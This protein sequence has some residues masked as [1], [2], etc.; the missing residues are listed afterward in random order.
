MRLG[1][2][3]ATG[4]EDS[5]VLGHAAATFTTAGNLDAALATYDRAANLA[6][7]SGKRTEAFDLSLAAAAI[8][9]RAQG[10]QAALPRYRQLALRQPLHPR[11]ASA[12]LTAVGLAA[13]LARQ[14]APGSLARRAV[15]RASISSVIGFDIGSPS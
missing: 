4:V 5:T 1:Q 7:K 6:R 14:S 9:N 3:L 10:P 13:A 12:H 8:I 15:S 2:A 11:A